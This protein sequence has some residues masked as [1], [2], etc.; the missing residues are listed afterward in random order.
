MTGS[1]SQ[2]SDSTSQNTANTSATSSTFIRDLVTASWASVGSLIKVTVDGHSI[3]GRIFCYDYSSKSLV[4]SKLNL[5]DSL[6][7]V[8]T[9]IDE[10]HYGDT[11]LINAKCVQDIMKLEQA[12][13]SKEEIRREFSC[14]DISQVELDR[15]YQQLDV[16]LEKR[17]LL[18]EQKK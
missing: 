8:E 18:L 17:R 14:G 11:V 4:L 9:L 15:V 7:N 12:P 5:S 3:T 10:D 1:H 6:L 16:Q 13:Q 2:H